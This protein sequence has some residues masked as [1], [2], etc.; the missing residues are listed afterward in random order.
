ML[1]IEELCTVL[2]AFSLFFALKEY[3][4]AR[5]RGESFF[6]QSS[7][8]ER[9]D[10]FQNLVKERMDSIVKESRLKGNFERN[11]RYYGRK[12]VDLAEYVEE[13]KI[14]GTQKS[15]VGYYLSDLI[16]WSKKGL[17]YKYV[18]SSKAEGETD[19]VLPDDG[20]DEIELEEEYSPVRGRKLFDYANH[21]YGRED[22]LY[23]LEQALQDIGEDEQDYRELKKE[24]DIK[25]TNVRFYLVDYAGKNVYT[26]F[27]DSSFRE[28]DTI[29]TYGRYLILD[30]KGLEY[31]SNM[32]VT[33]AY[34]YEL[35]N[36]YMSQFSGNYYLEFAVDT[37]YPAVDAFSVARDNYADYRS[38][39]IR[40]IIMVGASCLLVLIS[41]LI[42]MI[43]TGA[44]GKVRLYPFD[45]TKTE[46]AAVLLS[47]VL[48]FGIYVMV[49][50]V[51]RADSTATSYAILGGGTAALNIIFLTAYLS[52]VRRFKAGTLYSDSL[53]NWF[54][55]KW[56]YISSKR[57]EGKGSIA[58]RG[59]LFLLFILLNGVLVYVGTKIS[60]AGYIGALVLDLAV[61]V[62]YLNG[63][64][65]LGR[66]LF[67][68]EE[69]SRGNLE[70]GID[71]ENMN[72][73]NASLGSA[74]NSMSEGMRD[75]ME[76][77]IR[78]EKLKAD[79]ITNVSHDI[80]TPLTSIINYVDLLKRLD[81]EDEK[82]QSYIHV[83]DQKSA[84]LKVL[85]DDLVEASKIT[86]GNISLE[87]ASLDFGL[88]I[89]QMEG[90]VTERFEAADLSLITA[91]PD[92]SL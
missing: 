87:M 44:E 61:L 52:F 53:F 19:E 45:R 86:S 17:Q 85:T 64:A 27:P 83:L 4:G 90:E 7:V 14:S 9:T 34:L 33:D 76:V 65:Q 89:S 73:V 6:R 16:R 15:S 70:H 60:F 18:S 24:L 29:K 78:S 3:S 80:K 63:E 56:H 57:M 42:L 62:L 25:K 92:K 36:S 81:L 51:V 91:L 50:H 66:I 68:V 28:D 54:L 26:N 31:E 32:R 21:Y 13:G 43:Q 12:I 69:M 1:F 59:I 35:M 71:T 30:S 47:G 38:L 39:V 75:A 40:L 74:I 22:L 49:H 8:F 41:L 20:E 10:A 55:K 79:L 23:L 82:A 11:G 72:S 77:S 58:L 5:Q 48:V 2:L 37:D 67:G 84:R 46:I 88:F